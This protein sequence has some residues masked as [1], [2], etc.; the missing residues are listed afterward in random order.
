V[1]D[2]ARLAKKYPRSKQGREAA[3]RI[4][5]I[6][7][8]QGHWKESADAFSRL[9]GRS[10]HQERTAARY[11]QAR[12]LERAGSTVSARKIY[13]QILETEPTEY[14][15]HWAERHLGMQPP[16]TPGGDSI[17]ASPLVVIATEIAP[18]D[19]HLTRARELQ[20]ADLRSLARAELK[21][22]ERSQEMTRTLARFLVDSYPAVDGYRDAIRLA[23]K[24]GAKSREI[25]Y[26]LAFWPMVRQHT[27]QNGIDPF[28]VL[29][30]M[31]QES[32][33]DPAARS[34]AD[35]RG[36]M[37]LLPRTAEQVAEKLGRP[38]PVAY[39]YE[40]EVNI[41]LGIA[42]LAELHSRYGGNWLEILA[43]YNGGEGAVTKWQ[44]RF[45]NLDGDEFVESITYRETRDYVK[46]VFTH[47]RHYQ[48][49]YA[50]DGRITAGR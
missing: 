29:A 33:F 44:Q 21:A 9:A 6:R 45:G 4:A 49:L 42:H 7:Y 50:V 16:A 37:Q 12:S 34:S 24:A 31:R 17:E 43:A 48:E 18:G 32:L 39:L 46:R 11:W 25:L 27:R 15:A 36:A 22:F 14:Y 41:P 35:A 2:Y 3:W 47:Y 26:P 1:A 30:L 28:M 38:S 10:K 20:A 40:P 5:W 19:F 13:R 23:P 8:R